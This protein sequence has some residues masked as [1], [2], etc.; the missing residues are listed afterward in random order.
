[1]MGVME[2]IEMF[3]VVGAF[4]GFALSVY[5]LISMLDLSTAIKASK[6]MEFEQN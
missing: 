6:P 4:L 1:M 2:G 5:W 3:S